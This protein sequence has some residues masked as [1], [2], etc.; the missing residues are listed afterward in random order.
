MRVSGLNVYVQ[1]SVVGPSSIRTSRPAAGAE[2][3]ASTTAQRGISRG[4]TPQSVLSPNEQRFF[5]QLFPDLADRFSAAALDN[6]TAFDRR[7]RAE[8]P[9]A[10]PGGLFDARI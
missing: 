3:S 7:G 5:A 8:A 10:V 9:R 4:V 6:S 2:N 1:S